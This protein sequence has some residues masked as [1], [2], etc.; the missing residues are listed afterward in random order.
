ME[1]IQAKNALP[2]PIR[3]LVVDDSAFNRRTLTKILESHHAIK[4]VGV[5]ENGKEALR[6]IER[7]K[8]DLLTLDL[9]MPEMDGFTFLRILM[10]I[11]PLPVIVVSTRDGEKDVFKAMDLGAVD[12]IPKPTKRI[13]SKLFDI[14]DQLLEKVL[15][16]RGFRP[17]PIEAIST[18]RIE[19]RKT[20]HTGPRVETIAIGASTGGPSAIHWILSR[21]G[22]IPSVILL[23]QHMPPGF[24]KAFAERLD[25][26]C[27]MEVKEAEEGD[28]VKPGRVLLTPGGHHMTFE[29]V[30]GEVIVK[31]IKAARRDRY[32]PSIDLMFESAASI[33]GNGLM[34]IILTGMGND[35]ARG[36][37][38]VKEKG[39]YL[40]AES[41]DTALIFGMPEAV[42]S[43]GLVDEVLPLDD[44]GELIV[45][46]AG[47]KRS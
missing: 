7:L 3:V 42:I 16:V 41:R 47:A 17:R 45:R 5:A 19:G 2:E 46:W 14:R 38:K 43:T 37:K 12:F 27:A 13:S 36:A 22:F 1:G 9:H 44:I 34:G 28:L 26:E 11:N 24:T 25:R 32:A 21:I 30:G 18:K 20:L 31:L 15:S 6:Q 10:K 33:W 29:R 40:I 39:G 8:P 4:V 23:S 35:G